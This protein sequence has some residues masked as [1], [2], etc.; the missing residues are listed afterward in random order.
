MPLLTSRHLAKLLALFVV[1][2]VSRAML[3][4]QTESAR[5]SGLVTDSSGAV[6]AGADIMLQNTEQGTTSAVTTNSAGIYV[7]PSVR[8]GQYRISVRK[9]GFRSVDVLGVVVNVQDRIEE[10]VRLQPGSVSE[11][12]TVT[13]GAPLVNTQDA[14]VSTVVDRNFAENLPL[15]GRSFQTLLYLTPGVVPTVSGRGSGLDSG[16]F[17]VNGQRSDANYWMVD[18]VSGNASASTIFQGNQMA[19][20][21]GITSVFGGTSSLVPIDDMQEFRIQTSSV[22]PEFGRTPGA[23]I[24]IATRAGTN[25]FHGSLFDYFRNDALDANDWFNGV[26]ILNS[27]QLPKAEERQNDFGGTLGGPILKNRTFF[28]FSY[29][30]LRLRLPTTGLTTVPDAQTRKN[31]VPAMQ[32]FLNAFPLDP[33]QPDLVD[34]TAQFNATFSNPGTVNVANLRIDHRVNDKI[35]LFARYN[36]AP[37]HAAIRGPFQTMSLSTLDDSSSSAQQV[38]TGLNANP[39]NNFVN[40]FRFNYS[41]T[42][43]AGSWSL[44]D[45]GG[46]KPFS[47]PFP[48][49]YTP[50]DSAFGVLILGLQNPE[51]LTGLS[52]RNIQHQINLVDTVIYQKGSHSIKAGVDYRRL[53]P[54][55]SVPRY[56]QS[57][58]FF[59]VQDAEAGDNSSTALGLSNP[60]TLLLRNVGVFA[61]DTWRMLPTLTLTYGLRWDIDEAPSALSG[62]PVPALTGYNPAALSTVALAPLGTPAFHTSWSNVAPRVGVAYEMSP[63]SEWERVIRGGFGV[64]YDLA[65]SEIGNVIGETGGYPYFSSGIAPVSTFP[66]AGSAAVAPPIVPPTPANPQRIFG[67]DPGLRPPYTLQWNAAFQQGLGSEQ[68]LTFSYI[69]AAG[70]RLM[71]LTALGR[72]ANISPSFSILGVTA[73]SGTSDYNAL[74][75]Q[76]QRRMYKNIQLL[77]AYT[78]AHSIDTA[79]DGSGAL[80]SNRTSSIDNSPNRA[81]SDFDIRHSFTLGATYQIPRAGEHGFFTVLTSGWSV[82]TIALLHTSTPV[83][84]IDSNFVRLSNGFFA[85]IRPD[86]VPGIPLYLYGSQYPGGKAFNNT[87]GAVP[88]GCPDGFPSVGPFCDPPFDASFSPIRQG[89][90]GRNSL[91]GFGLEQWDFAVH[92]DFPVTESVRLQ[93]RA[94]MFN[95]LNHPN[96]APPQADITSPD[97]GLSTQTQA[98]YLGS[99]SGGSGLSPIYQIGGPR[100]I[101]LALK[102]FF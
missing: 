49:P 84:L 28:F 59:S 99:G 54:Y 40:E 81:S 13:G 23:Q 92:R 77:G 60:A 82:Q 21:T 94:E 10:N 62:P 55:Y 67:F 15:N 38:T 18:G 19:G 66:V 80:S 41:K 90:A 97:F 57:G 27:V 87:P 2:C 75:V 69:G 34:G 85:A 3:S 24:S 7:L 29:E 36:Y 26:N 44:D 63:R 1:L 8:P 48:S 5:I 98:T 78:W 91:R 93:F 76:F 101:Q 46:A 14:S 35:T 73:G 32:P 16:Q 95:F 31:A 79:S 30:G 9:D 96:F 51:V 12:V 100:S 4:A 50:T 11:S 37:S 88:G 102:L 47:P 39:T 6:I 71:Q 83:S 56:D 45:F 89:N 25:T 42:D 61:Q 52:A 58:L 20:A 33:V 68:A 43:A 72:G 22:A 74:Q 17:S 70:R 86:V 65:T 64:F 53:S